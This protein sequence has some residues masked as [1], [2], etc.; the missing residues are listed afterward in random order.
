MKN[1]N[2]SSCMA[3]CMGQICTYGAAL[4]DLSPSENEHYV[5]GSVT[6]P[7]VPLVSLC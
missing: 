3:S 2:Y 1:S 4:A 7:A 5:M 6:R